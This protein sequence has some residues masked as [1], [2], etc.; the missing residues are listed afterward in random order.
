MSKIQALRR[1]PGRVAVL[2]CLAVLPAL[3]SGCDPKLAAA[4]AAPP[5]QVG[6][7]T[8]SPEPVK[9]TTD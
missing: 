7:V 2:A 5:P 8:V 4:P 3:A 1:H 9:R 6:V